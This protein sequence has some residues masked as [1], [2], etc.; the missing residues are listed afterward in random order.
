M[1][2][3]SVHL[4]REVQKESLPT[5][6]ACIAGKSKVNW[7]VR[8]FTASNLLVCLICTKLQNVRNILLSYLFYIICD[9]SVLQEY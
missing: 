9:S 8:I 2:D 5:S 6:H 3:T 1:E 4:T 7:C